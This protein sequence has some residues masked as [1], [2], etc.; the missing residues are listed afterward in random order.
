V[1]L[2]CQSSRAVPGLRGSAPL[3]RG[4]HTPRRCSGL[5][6]LSGQRA[7]RP[8]SCLARAAPDRA[9]HTAPTRRRR[10]ALVL[11]PD[12]RLARV[13]VIPTARAPT[14]AVRSCVARTAPAVVRRR[15]R[16]GEPPSPPS[17]VRRRRVVTGSS[18]SAA[19]PCAARAARP[20]PWAAPA[21][22]TRTVPRVAAGRARAVRVG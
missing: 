20:R 12:C 14:T 9:P 10:L 3:P 6:P 18:S 4:C 13:T 7:A 17:P 8:N 2:T 1:G 21:L 15:L 22:R 11:R 5:K 16:A 19:V